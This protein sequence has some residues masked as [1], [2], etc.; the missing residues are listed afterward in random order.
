MARFD[1]PLDN[2]KIASPCSAD[3]NEM[4]GN[5][6]KRFCGECKLNVYNLSG[7]TKYDAE[8]LLRVSEGRLCVR[9]FQRRDGS[10]L[11]ADCP[12]GWAMVKQRISV[13]A[14]AAFSV[15]LALLGTLAAVSLLGKNIESVRRAVTPFVPFTE[16]PVVMGNIATPRPTPTTDSNK[17]KLRQTIGKPARPAGK[18]A[19]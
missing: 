2:I 7:M 1:S 8:N 3:W 19:E 6:R 17:D 14:S 12:V 16:K 5:E 15:L 10:V 4:Q 11:T 9:Y 13:C 18:F